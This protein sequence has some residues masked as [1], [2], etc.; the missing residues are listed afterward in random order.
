MMRVGEVR[1]A[2]DADFSKLR[3]MCHEEEEWD[4]KYGPSST[5]K[6]SKPT[7]KSRPHRIDA[8]AAC[9]ITIQRRVLTIKY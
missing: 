1:V 6:V 8:Y 2:E 4:L 7:A 3:E 9:S 5:T